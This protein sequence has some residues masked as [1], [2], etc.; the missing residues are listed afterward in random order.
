MKLRILNILSAFLV[1]TGI[2]VLTFFAIAR[3]TIAPTTKVLE[4]PKT[5]SEQSSK[6]LGDNTYLITPEFDQIDQNI[7]AK[8]FLVYFDD[9]KQEIVGKNTDTTLAIASIT[10]L[11]TAFIVQKYGNLSDVWAITQKGTNNIRP[12]LGLQVGD[13]VLVSDLVKSMLVGSA[14]DAAQ[15]LGEY[16]SHKSKLST[17]GLMNQ[18]AKELGMQSTHY[19]NT[20]G[21]D[22][23]QNYSTANDIKKLLVAIT[24]LLEQMQTDRDQSYSFVSENGN[25]YRVNATNKLLSI[26]PEIHAIKTGFTDEAGEAMITSVLHK[27]LKFTI[28]VLGSSDREKDTETLKKRIIQKLQ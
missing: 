27:N 11:M 28:I 25:S 2:I 5:D 7:S 18:T 9:S 3:P 23:E 19:A 4:A 22:S 16:A 20:N 17:V 8:S 15:S 13:R 24:P 12:I 14:N 26:D 6:I 1:G 10:K 21:W